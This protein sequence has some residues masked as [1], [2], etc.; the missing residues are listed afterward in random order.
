MLTVEPAPW[1]RRLLL[2]VLAGLGLLVFAH[3]WLM[4]RHLTFVS[5]VHRA[6]HPIATPLQRVRPGYT[7]DVN[8]WIRHALSF[9][10]GKE[11]VRIRH[12]DVDNAP[13]GREVH[14]NSALSWWLAGLGWTL[15]QITGLPTPAAVERAAV[16][17]NLPL[18]LGLTT[19]MAWWTGRRLGALA[20]AMVAIGLF[21]HRSLY[22]GFLPA[23]PDHHGLI[24]IGLLGMFLGVLFMGGGWVRGESDQSGLSLLPADE[25]CAL[26][27]ARLSGF[28]GGF[29]LWISTAS[30]A[31]PLAVVPLAGALASMVS[32]KS[33]SRQGARFAP[34][35]WRTWG[36][37]GA[38][39][40]LAF[41]LLEYF[42]SNLSWRLE[43]NHPLYA[44]SWWAGAELAAC[45]L[46]VIAAPAEERREPARQ[47]ARQALWTVPASLAPALVI[48]LFGT[49]VFL[50]LDPF[51]VRL[52]STIAEFLPFQTRLGMDS[53]WERLDYLVVHPVFYL[54]AV[55]LI[56]FVSRAAR[57]PL[58]L[59]LVPAVLLQALG[60]WQGRWAMSAGAAH[61]PLLLA[62][63]GC[64][65][66]LPFFGGS[67][68]RRWISGG[69]A[70]LFFF[71][72]A[73]VYYF[74]NTL[75]A[76]RNNIVPLDETLELVYREIAQAIRDSQPRGPIVLFASPNAS[77]GIGY[78]GRF[79]TLGTLYW[80][81]LPGLLAAA[82]LNS[83]PGDNAAALIVRRL[84][85]THLALVS[86]DNYIEEY[87]QFL[88][89]GLSQA[90]VKRTF[91]YQLLGEGRIPV[92][93]EPI[94]YRPPGDLPG[95]LGPLRVLLFRVNFEQNETTL[96]YRLGLLL[97]LHDQLEVALERFARV[98]QLDPKAAA[99]WLRRAEIL[100][101]QK[102]WTAAA[103]NLRRGAAL[104][105]PAERY[106][107]LTQSAI[108][109]ERVGE[110]SLAITLYRDAIAQPMTNAVALNNLAWRLATS[111]RADLRNPAEALRCAEA[112]YQAE[113][114]SATGADTLAAALAANNRFA[115]AITV[116]DHAI[117]LASKSGDTAAV[118]EYSRRQNAYRA[119]LPW[120]E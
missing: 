72:P 112:A 108:A 56:P 103:D 81:N 76:V 62:G 78:Y 82:E 105:E 88:H 38:I 83:A 19:V 79:Q 80:E 120:R 118:Q 116:S 115:E 4:D 69:L 95:A 16:W 54:A 35:V 68:R 97:T 5:G 30:L 51:L 73:P 101:R 102:N 70:A 98:I 60:F 18:F 11:G 59:M 57:L 106:R 42:P 111:A 26:S 3:T 61:L 10:E 117:Q 39:T 64:A 55:A 90:G 6:D 29:G 110:Y 31:L 53:L 58:V 41:Y 50:P 7:A 49:V 99:P 25:T 84:G 13:H 21:G 86:R 65:Y 89:P 52:H 94:L 100:M 46:T 15:H 37:A 71:A 104:S 63:L 24:A 75:H 33:L 85:V 44:L 12:T 14:W 74:K 109:L 27:A 36:R 34:E 96:Y 22:E 17:A 28:W 77:V 87:A 2:V 113:P 93:L 47:L 1:R 43:V 67:E 114:N 8:M 9:L 92:W 45:V 23:Y 20:G 119:G 107:L 91:G 40:S 66:T 48:A 32:G